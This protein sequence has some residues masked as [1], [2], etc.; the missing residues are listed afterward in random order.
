M[1][2]DRWVTTGDPAPPSRHPS[3]DEGTAVESHTLRER[4][5]A[6]PGAVFPP[7]PTRAIRLDYGPDQ[8]LG[9]TT[10]LPP[11]EGETYPALVSDVDDDCNEVGGIRLPDVSVP[12]ATN[13]GWN[14]RHPDVGNP[15]LVIG[16]TGG[17]MGGTLPF[18]ATRQER[19]SYGRPPPVHRGA[20]HLGGRL[21]RKGLPKPPPG[22]WSEGYL[23]DGGR[24]RS[25]RVRSG[26]ATGTGRAAST[27][28]R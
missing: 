26:T 11:G 13:T 23:L 16:I 4:F 5:E 18:A 20:L 24:G 10:K 17:L 21:R 8:A 1:N 9:R 15:D 7:R 12:L 22:W 3:L 27:P 25:G 6:I 2:L 28:R 14:L 19:E